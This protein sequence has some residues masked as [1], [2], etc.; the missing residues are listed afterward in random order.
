MTR[1]KRPAKRQDPSLPNENILIV[2]A[3]GSGKSAFLRETV[4]FKQRRII[5]WDPEE[6]YPLPRVR[7]LEAFLKL[8]RKSGF[9]PIRCALT[10]APTEENFEQFS[11]IAFALAHAAA[12]MTIIADEIAD[13][14]RV[15]KASFHWGQLCRKVRKYGGRL[16]AITQ[17]PQEADKTIMNQVEYTWC[18]ALK[19]TASAKYMAAEMGITLEKLQSIQNIHRKQVQ[20][21]IRK[22]TDAATMETIK[23]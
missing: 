5:A 16:C 12:P 15:S 7:S 1:A 17:R 6:D 13:V 2:G 3:S 14:T 18:G 19:T 11:A 21:W 8:A 4:D 22:G 10:V 9:G 23:F 20:Y